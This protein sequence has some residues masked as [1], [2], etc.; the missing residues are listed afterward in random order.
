MNKLAITALALTGVCVS[1]RAEVQWL[2]TFYDFGTIKES[3]GIKS[4]FVRF[5]NLSDEPVV[6]LEAK[7]SCGCTTSSFT[8]EPINRGD[9][10]TISFAFNPDGRPGKIDKS[11]RVRLSGGRIY[12][13]PLRGAVL[14]T[15]ET[16]EKFYPYDA[17]LLRL[18]DNR[19]FGGNVTKGKMPSH[20]LKV[21]N[22]AD[23]PVKINVTS[24]EKALKAEV[25][26]SELEPGGITTIMVSLDSGKFEK[27]AELNIPISI[28]AD[29]EEPYTI[30]YS[31]TLI[32]P[33][34]VIKKK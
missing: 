2:D 21:Y 22:Q 19:I 10:A 7:P 20:F 5:V 30:I 9:T 6:I 33:S 4:G 16:L 13:I 12:R 8:E 29:D 17:G 23:H 15:P 25:A 26:E 11:V 31:A 27:G 24:G 28:Q 14:G 32:V 18:S 1:A 3:E 34:V